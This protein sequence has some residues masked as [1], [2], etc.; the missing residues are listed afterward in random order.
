MFHQKLQYYIH[1][2]GIFNACILNQ[3]ICSKSNFYLKLN[4]DSDINAHLKIFL[5]ILHEESIM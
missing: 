4:T 1:T 3:R 5:A 2:K